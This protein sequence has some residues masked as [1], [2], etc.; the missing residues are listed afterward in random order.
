M[1]NR[2]C[3]EEVSLS[4]YLD[5]ELG[6]GIAG[7]V[8]VHLAACGKCSALFESMKSERDL[9][10]QSLPGTEP[11]AR[12]KLQL[13]ERIDAAPEMRPGLLQWIK[14]GQILSL[15]SRP[16]AYACVS[17]LFLAAVISA[18]NFQRRTENGRLLAEIDRSKAEWVARDNALNPFNID[19]NGAPL[20]IAA[21]NPFKAYLNER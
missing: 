15:R 9:L 14:T 11:P 17:I 13:F 7:Q 5:G 1:S 6:P 12:M 21:G 20:R 4:A 18:F 16:W 2:D 19:T 10:L 8:E 3:I